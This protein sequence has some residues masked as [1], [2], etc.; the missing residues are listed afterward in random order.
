MHQAPLGH[1]D[2]W[3]AWAILVTFPPIS[4]P[5]EPVKQK[6]MLSEQRKR[7]E[8]ERRKREGREG[9]EGVRI[10]KSGIFQSTDHHSHRVLIIKLILST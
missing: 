8:R 2:K 4:A 7:G 9:G 1:C 5:T 6:Q 3:A 10:C